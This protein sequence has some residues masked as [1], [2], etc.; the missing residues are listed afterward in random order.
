MK[1]TTDSGNTDGWLHKTSVYSGTCWYVLQKNDPRIIGREPVP[2]F[3][4]TMSSAT[5]QPQH[6]NGLVNH[7]YAHRPLP[8][9]KPI[10]L[11][12]LAH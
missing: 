7:K 11:W 6:Q 4:V 5:T 2:M 12:K 1:Q 10:E 9:S 3:L 8:S